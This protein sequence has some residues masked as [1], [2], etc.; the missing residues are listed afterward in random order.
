MKTFLQILLVLFAATL[1]FIALPAAYTR[2]DQAVRVLSSSGYSNIEITGWRPFMA[3]EEDTFS[4][5]FRAKSPNGSV[6]TGAVTS[7]VLKGAT[8]RLD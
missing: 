1:L 4:T 3:G 8:I 5:G 2:P 6:V 7:G